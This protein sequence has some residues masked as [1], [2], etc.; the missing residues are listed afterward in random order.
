MNI[1]SPIKLSKQ[2]LSLIGQIIGL[3]LFIQLLSGLI[4]LGMRGVDDQIL[5]YESK[6]IIIHT[7]IVFLFTPAIIYLI[8]AWSVGFSF[9]QTPFFFE[10]A[11]NY[12][13]DWN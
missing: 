9:K 5:D 8:K 12:N 7:S 10:N 6:V 3:L 2:Q 1:N 13:I 11:W 4:G